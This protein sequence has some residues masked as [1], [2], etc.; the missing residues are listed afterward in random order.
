MYKLLYSS[1]NRIQNGLG[2]VLG[3][4]LKDK[5][6]NIR[7]IGDEFLTIKLVLEKVITPI[8][9]RILHKLVWT[10]RL[11]Q[12][13]DSLDKLVQEITLAEKVLVC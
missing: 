2:I 6:I 12:F 4:D 8:I 10:K 5:I 7:I 3:Q 1:V 13:W 11:R 9:S